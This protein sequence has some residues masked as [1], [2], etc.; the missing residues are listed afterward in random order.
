MSN[1]LNLKVM[2]NYLNLNL[3]NKNISLLVYSRINDTTVNQ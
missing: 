3:N 2:S 1:Y